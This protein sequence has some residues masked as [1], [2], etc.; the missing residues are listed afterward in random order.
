[1]ALMAVGLARS[2]CKSHYLRAMHTHRVLRHSDWFCNN[3]EGSVTIQYPGIPEVT[4]DNDAF[5]SF[6]CFWT[7]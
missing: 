3:D 4:F 5:S 1:M 2:S 6:V 7:G